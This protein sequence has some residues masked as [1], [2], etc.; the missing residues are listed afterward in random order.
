MLESLGIEPEAWLELLEVES[1]SELSDELDELDE[2]D[3]PEQVKS[4]ISSY[5]LRAEARRR[6]IC[7]QDLS[8]S[9]EPQQLLQFS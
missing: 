4:F 6:A 1:S 8:A 5:A 9:A 3:E 7:S 2:F